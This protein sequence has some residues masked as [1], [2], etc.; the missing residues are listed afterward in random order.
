MFILFHVHFLPPFGH[1][2]VA[3]RVNANRNYRQKDAYCVD[4][5]C[6]R[7]TNKEGKGWGLDCGVLRITINVRVRN[8]FSLGLG[9]GF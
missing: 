2:F 1:F 3:L 4:V 9:L 6:R 8:W 7:K 5:A